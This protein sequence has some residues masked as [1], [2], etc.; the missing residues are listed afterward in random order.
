MAILDIKTFPSEILKQ[1]A[2]PIKYVDKEIR[3]LAENMSETMYDKKGVGLAAPQVGNLLRL[4][5]YDI[6][7]GLCILI[8]PEIIGCE[9]R[10][11][12]EEGCLSIPGIRVEV[13]RY[14]IIRVTGINLKGERVSFETKDLLARVIQ[15]EIDHLNGNLIL[16]KVSRLKRELIIRKLKKN[17]KSTSK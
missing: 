16:D 2:N 10:I 11:K 13:P 17:Y 15:H 9:G 4:I 7:E 12:A 8:N 5:T 1:K 14:E 6:G 3:K